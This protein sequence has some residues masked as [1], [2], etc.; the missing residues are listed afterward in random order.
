MHKCI[1][2]ADM[3]LRR[4]FE[5]A[6]RQPWYSNTVFVITSDHTNMSDH[7]EYRSSIGVFSAPIIFFDTSGQLPAGVKPGVAQQIDIMPTL[8]SLLGYDRPYVAFGKDLLATAP[9][10]MWT[11]NYSNGIYQY[12]RGDTLVQFDGERVV[13]SYWLIFLTATPAGSPLMVMP[14]SEAVSRKKGLEW[15]E[16]LTRTVLPPPRM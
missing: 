2:Y 9:D 3:A 1:R 4:F 11:V 16:R 6:S 10:S 7:D 13:A 15:P 8:L 5:T 12:L 14:S